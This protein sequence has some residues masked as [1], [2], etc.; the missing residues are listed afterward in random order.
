MPKK[1]ANDGLARAI[2]AGVKKEMSRSRVAKSARKKYEK[3]GS[4]VPMT[5]PRKPPGCREIEIP[6]EPGLQ[7]SIQ[8][9]LRTPPAKPRLVLSSINPTKS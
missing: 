7:K 6:F 3:L 4:S 1:K 5:K 8:I 2:L 9:D